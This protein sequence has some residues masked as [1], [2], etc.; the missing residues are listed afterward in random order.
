[1][2]LRKSAKGRE[3]L[4]RIS[5]KNVKTGFGHDL[6]GLYADFSL[7]GKKMGYINDDGWGGESEIRFE[8]KKHEEIFNAFLKDNNVGQLMFENG[9]EFMESADKIDLHSQ[10]DDLIND[11]VNMI[12]QKKAEKKLEKKTLKAIVIGELDENGGLVAYRETTWGKPLEQVALGALQMTYNDRK[13]KLKPN[14]KILNTNLER[15]GVKL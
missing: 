4:N 8:S 12:E 14:E 10:A 7:D 11:A 3:I 15:L 13:K 9:W 1:M 5:L 6:N 2:S